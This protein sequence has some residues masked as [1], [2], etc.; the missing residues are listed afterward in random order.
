MGGMTVYCMRCGREIGEEQVFCPECLADMEKYPV[1]PGTAVRLPQ[2]SAVQHVRKA[3]PRKKPPAPEEVNLRLRKLLRF[4]V[5][6]WL[7]T[8]LVAAALAYPA[9]L[10]AVEENHFLPGQNYSVFEEILPGKNDK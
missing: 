9:Y 1:K 8:L 3:A 10:Y 4:F 2:R 5:V 6:L 7:V